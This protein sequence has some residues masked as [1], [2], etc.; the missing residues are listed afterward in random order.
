ML[1]RDLTKPENANLK[2]PSLLEDR[3]KK[4]NDIF[5]PY[6]ILTDVL[7]LSIVGL[8]IG[9]FTGWFFIGVSKKLIGWP[10]MI[11][12]ILMSLVG[13]FLFIS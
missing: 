12:F 3:K 9:F 6:Y 13:S 4:I 5:I 7:V 2:E 11:M 1:N 8:L 10:G